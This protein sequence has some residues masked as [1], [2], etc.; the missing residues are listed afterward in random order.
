M[1]SSHACAGRPR[2]RFSVNMRCALGRCVLG[3]VRARRL[4]PGCSA[5]GRRCAAACL[6]CQ[7]AASSEQRWRW[8]CRGGRGSD[9]ACSPRLRSVGTLRTVLLAATLCRA[10]APSPSSS[11]SEQIALK[12]RASG[13]ER[14]RVLRARR[15]PPNISARRARGFPPPGRQV[16]VHK[17]S[18]YQK[19]ARLISE[20]ISLAVQPWARSKVTRGCV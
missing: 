14:L 20:D 7:R 15:A 1:G 3:L 11:E 18:T 17:A 12:K 16:T 8:S 10:L 13:S 2:D 19:R 9:H 6:G 4:G 5:G